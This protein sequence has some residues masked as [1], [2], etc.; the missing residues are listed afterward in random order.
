MSTALQIA[1]RLRAA[2]LAQLQ[3]LLKLYAATTEAHRQIQ[4]ELTRRR[5][6]LNGQRQTTKAK[7]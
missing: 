3:R 7:S 2:S 1:A 6:K 5:Q 4:K